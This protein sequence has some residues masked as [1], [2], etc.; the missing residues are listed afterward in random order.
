MDRENGPVSE[1]VVD[2][3]V[4]PFY[5]QA[6]LHKVFFLESCL[7]GRRQKSVPVRRSPAESEL[8][9]CGFLQAPALEIGMSEGLSLLGLKIFCEKLPGKL[10]HEH[11]TLPLLPPG[12]VFGAF[13]LFPDLY[14]VFGSEI[15]Q[16][17]DIGQAF[18]LHD[19]TYGSA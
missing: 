2:L 1:P 15:F 12:D 10:G 7:F 6:G 13:F 19:E 5:A 11:E 17:I 3:A 8:A 18:M 16:C 14:M 9:D 4:V